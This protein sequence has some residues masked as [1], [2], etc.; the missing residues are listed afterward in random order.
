MF[1]DVMNYQEAWALIYFIGDGR[2]PIRAARA[3]FPERPKGYLAATMKLREYAYYK[4]SAENRELLRETRIEYARLC[5]RV[6]V[7]LPAYARYIPFIT[8]VCGE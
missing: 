1:I 3:L 5:G 7:E 6:W 4:A 8:V 2:R